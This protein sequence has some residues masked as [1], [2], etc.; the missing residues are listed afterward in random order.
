A[1]DA[2]VFALKL[3][4]DSKVANRDMDKAVEILLENHVDNPKIK[5]ALAPMNAAGKKGQQFIKTVAEKS[6]KAE[7]QGLAFYYVALA[8]SAEAADHESG[9]FNI[10]ADKLRGMAIEAMEKAIK[11]APEA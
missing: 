11:L 9:G 5:D 2:A 7:I 8:H 10:S 6:T 3:L 1:I 4:G